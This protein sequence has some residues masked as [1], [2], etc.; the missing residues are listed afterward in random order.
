MGKTFFLQEQ[1]F[2][3][4]LR[5]CLKRKSL[6]QDME[7]TVQLLF[8]YLKTTGNYLS[9]GITDALLRYYTRG[10][11]GGPLAKVLF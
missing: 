4:W 5:I 11:D 6:G 1:V 3:P 2:V 9:K 8:E 7:R 10:S